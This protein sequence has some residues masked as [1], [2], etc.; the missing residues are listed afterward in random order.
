MHRAKKA[1]HLQATET[2][3]VHQPN[4]LGHLA[5]N[6]NEWTTQAIESTCH[7]E[8][9]VWAYQEPCE[10]AL[11]CPQRAVRKDRPKPSNC[12]ILECAGHPDGSRCGSDRVVSTRGWCRTAADRPHVRN[13]KKEAGCCMKGSH[14]P[15]YCVPCLALMAKAKP[16]RKI[17]SSTL[18]TKPHLKKRESM[19]FPEA[20]AM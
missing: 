11:C 8:S 16:C 18:V 3:G 12:P 15:A 6:R 19:P 9:S 4:T 20:N 10:T 5:A 13:Y 17:P 14:L 7:A 1:C 2:D